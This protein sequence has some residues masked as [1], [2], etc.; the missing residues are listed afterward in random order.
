MEGAKKRTDNILNPGVLYLQVK[1]NAYI[2]LTNEPK[3]KISRRL[4]FGWFESRGRKK[5]SSLQKGV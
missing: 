3:H 1:N 2:L 5:A 4:T